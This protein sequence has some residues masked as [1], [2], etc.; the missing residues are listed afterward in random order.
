MR[1]FK[2]L[3]R[4]AKEFF[5]FALQNKAW[6]IVPIVVTMLMLSALIISGSVTLPFFVYT[7]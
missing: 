7:F 4:L 2:Y 6:W 5:A 3:G 1:M